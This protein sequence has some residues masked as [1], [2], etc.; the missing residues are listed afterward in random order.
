MGST[1]CSAGFAM[2]DITPP[3]GVRI[4]GYYVVRETKGVLDPIYVRALAFREGDKTAVMLVLD[5]LGMYGP[6][7]VEWPPMIAQRL[8]LPREAVFVCCTHSHTTP[9]V[10]SYREPHDDQYDAWL[11]RRLGDAAQMAI[12]DLKPVTEVRGGETLV[13]GF[14]FVR[15]WV[16]KDGTVQTNPAFATAEQRALLDHPAHETDDSARLMRIIREDAPELVII[17]FQ[18]HPDMIGGEYISADHPG[19]LCRRV[20]E[21]APN[22]RCIYLDGAEG[23]LTRTNRFDTNWQYAKG[24]EGAMEYGRNLAD[25]IMKIY[26]TVP[27]THM[28]GLSFGQ[29]F[30]RARTKRGLLPLEECQRIIDAHEAGRKEEISDNP[31]LAMYLAAQAYS[32]KDMELQQIDYY[33]LPVTGI[34]FC[35]LAFIGIPGEPFNEVG[36]QV[37]GNSKF[38]VTSVCCQANGNYGY[39]PT[40]TAYDQGGYEPHNTRL[41]KGVAEQLADSADALLAGF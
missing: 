28:T 20:E 1:N 16:M 37:R 4:G 27:S 12:D 33:D 38:P 36:K 10:T 5:M 23:Q 35:G 13:P 3:L 30:V 8:G 21:L 17:N 41:L 14:T 19:A 7:A 25:A 22:T 39:Y 26:D 32:V 34:V 31:K 24:W 40:A 6:A 2:L 15:R 9:V 11:Y 29:N 18:V